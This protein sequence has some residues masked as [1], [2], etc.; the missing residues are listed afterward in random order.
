MLLHTIRS[1]CPHFPTVFT[2]L[3]LAQFVCKNLISFN[4]L[5]VAYYADSYQSITLRD[6]D[7]FTH[8]H[9]HKSALSYVFSIRVGEYR[10]NN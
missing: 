8:T 1:I 6:I 5:F 4:L 3:C 10:N 9:K 7:S 2:V